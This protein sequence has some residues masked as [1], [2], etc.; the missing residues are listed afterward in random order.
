MGLTAMPMA[1]V[2]V[3]PLETRGGDWASCRR[4]GVA[5]RS[6]RAASPVLVRRKERLEV[7][8]TEHVPGTKPVGRLEPDVVAEDQCCL[9]GLDEYLPL[10]EPQP[11]H[12]GRAVGQLK[13]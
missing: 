13:G 5:G 1:S 12:R 11:S 3:A 6:T 7:A 10:V 8:G 4:V 9:V 2:L